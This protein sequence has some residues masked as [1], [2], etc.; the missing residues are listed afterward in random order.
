MRK[1]GVDR[2]GALHVDGAPEGGARA[3]G[4]RGRHAQQGE[5]MRLLEGEQ[6]AAE[7]C[8]ACR[9]RGSNAW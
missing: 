6:R 3:G 9:R 4:E 1:Y 7:L 5:P 8:E 2:T